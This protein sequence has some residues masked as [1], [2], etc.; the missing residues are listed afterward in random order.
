MTIYQWNVFLAV[1]EQ[2]SFV[3][4][5]RVLNVTQSAV[6]H[7]IAKMEEEYGYPFFIRN[8]NNVELTSSGS[9]CHWAGIG[10]QK[11]MAKVFLGK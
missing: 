11:D 2:K 6:S 7:T 3:R 9:R 8:K 1:A 10:S 5:A 4:A